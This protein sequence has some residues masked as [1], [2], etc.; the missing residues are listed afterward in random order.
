MISKI[1]KLTIAL[2]SA[3]LSTQQVPKTFTEEGLPGD[4]I[5]LSIPGDAAVKRLSNP[6]TSFLTSDNTAAVRPAPHELADSLAVDA[7]LVDCKTFVD[8]PDGYDLRLMC[9]YGPTEVNTGKYVLRE[10][11]VTIINSGVAGVTA[12]YSVPRL[13]GRTWNITVPWIS[14]VPFEMFGTWVSGKLLFLSFVPATN[15]NNTLCRILRFATATGTMEADAQYE[16]PAKFIPKHDPK[17][18]MTPANRVIVFDPL[19]TLKDVNKQTPNNFILVVDMP[20]GSPVGWFYLQVVAPDFNS[21][22][23]YD[24]MT[25]NQNNLHVLGFEPDPVDPLKCSA[26]AV[27]LQ[28]ITSGSPATLSFLKIG[29]HSTVASNLSLQ[30]FLHFIFQKL[31]SDLY[32]RADS[33][34]AFTGVIL[35]ESIPNTPQDN[36]LM[37]IKRYNPGLVQEANWI[38]YPMRT[39]PERLDIR[40]GQLSFNSHSFNLRYYDLNK[41]LVYVDFLTVASWYNSWSTY[42]EYASLLYIVRWPIYRCNRAYSFLTE[43]RAAS[44]TFISTVSTTPALNPLFCIDKNIILS[45]HAGRF[46]NIWPS[47][48]VH[49]FPQ[50]STVLVSK[51]S[52]Q[53]RNS[54]VTN[55][56][57]LT[58]EAAPNIPFELTTIPS[59]F[60]NLT[61]PTPLITILG[62][63]N[64]RFPIFG[65][66]DSVLGSSYSLSIIEPVIP[67]LSLVSSRVANMTIVRG[68]DNS[69]NIDIDE[70]FI[71]LDKMIGVHHNKR[72]GLYNTT[73]TTT[74]LGDVV[75]RATLASHT[76][77]VNATVLSVKMSGDF[78]VILGRS[79]V[80]QVFLIQLVNHKTNFWYPLQ[81]INKPTYTDIEATMFRGFMVVLCYKQYNTPLEP[82]EEMVYRLSDRTLASPLFPADGFGCKALFGIISM[83]ILPQSTTEQRLHMMLHLPVAKVAE[84]RSLTL[85]FRSDADPVPAFYPLRSEF[86]NIEKWN[87]APKACFFNTKFIIYN[88]ASI[89][90][91]TAMTGELYSAKTGSYYTNLKYRIKEDLNLTT[92]KQIKCHGAQL[93]MFTVYGEQR[94]DEAKNGVLVPYSVFA[95]YTFEDQPQ[96]RMHSLIKTKKLYNT[97][98]ITDDGL[99]NVYMDLKE[100][101]ISEYLV[102]KKPTRYNYFDFIAG[103]VPGISYSIKFRL[104]NPFHSME[105]TAALT[106]STDTKITATPAKD[107]KYSQGL[108]LPLIPGILTALE[109]PIITTSLVI[110]GSNVVLVNPRV[111]PN[112]VQNLAINFEGIPQGSG[113]ILTHLDNEILVVYVAQGNK[114]VCYRN[115]VLLSEYKIPLVPPSLT[116]LAVTK[117]K[118]AHQVDWNRF[119]IIYGSSDYFRAVQYM[120]DSNTWV[121]PWSAFVRF[122]SFAAFPSSQNFGDSNSDFEVYLSPCPINQFNQMTSQYQ[123]FPIFVSATN[124]ASPVFGRNYPISS[125]ASLSYLYLY[126]DNSRMT[127]AMPQLLTSCSLVEQRTNPQWISL[128]VCLTKTEPRRIAI[129]NQNIDQPQTRS[130]VWEVIDFGSINSQTFED[131]KCALRSN[132]EISCMTIDGFYSFRQIIITRKTDRATCPF[133]SFCGEITKNE[134]YSNYLS[135]LSIKHFLV[136]RDYFAVGIENS[137]KKTEFMIFKYGIRNVYSLMAAEGEPNDVFSCGFAT[138]NRL[139]IVNARTG[140]FQVAQINEL[141]VT[142]RDP[143]HTGISSQIEIA[144]YNNTLTPVTINLK[145]IFQS[146]QV[147]NTPVVPPQ[148]GFFQKYM[149]WLIGGGVLAVGAVLA[150]LYLMRRE[151]IIREVK[152]KNDSSTIRKLE[153][154]YF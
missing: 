93:E 63:R 97:V 36:Q 47:T 91:I 18:M 5:S 119:I 40:V 106:L 45:F 67:N 95:V 10:M 66:K 86:F 13:T 129:Y 61:I 38:I 121:A 56:S 149:W 123:F 8:E 33:N 34:V 94:V 43:S 98:K 89:D 15:P 110:K 103:N 81:T 73:N 100:Y 135:G 62:S 31:R 136:D 153:E 58:Q 35:H 6:F 102:F 137:K 28:T 70:S 124:I 26:K 50:T 74:S 151:R 55:P 138:D 2:L 1:L 30:S 130:I 65:S 141:S 128:L 115:F 49:S 127:P 44:S 134:P 68:D 105:F 145:D 112:S 57:N 69:A 82:V 117:L 108:T 24:L 29:I 104:W 42:D 39:P 27:R 150:A 71:V 88:D 21:T 54:R 131:F 52:L 109:G 146:N 17:V 7:V 75:L 101:A 83:T 143:D 96:R 122:F 64:A 133:G 87:T 120:L 16:I 90:E 114:L 144:N 51:G 14:P 92:L 118:V 116:P 53:L 77:F 147:S 32:E 46:N 99:E 60:S 154:F 85:R 72:L 142:F 76:P 140:V 79:W 3:L 80:N 132:V 59:V 126:S 78:I 9:M 20:I 111:N 37:K 48:T 148:P 152:E 113:S 19:D 107:L 84:I 22:Y 23:I 25:D 139:Y 41:Q 4:I 11:S 125:I 12:S